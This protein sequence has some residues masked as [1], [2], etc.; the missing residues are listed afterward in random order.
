MR[1]VV[2]FLFIFAGI[3]NG[4]QT[5]KARQVISYDDELSTL[6]DRVTDR[7]LLNQTELLELHHSIGAQNRTQTVGNSKDMMCSRDQKRI[8]LYASHHKSGTE[9]FRNLARYQSLLLGQPPCVNNGCA[10]N[11]GPCTY[12]YPS[13]LTDPAHVYFSCHLFV[14]QLEAIQKFSG[15]DWRAVHVIRDPVALVVS[16]Y[17]YHMRSGNRDLDGQTAAI[18][19]MPMTE[20]LRI[21]AEFALTNAIP[22]MVNAVQW[23]TDHSKNTLVLRL[24]EFTR[25]SQAYDATVRRLYD[26]LAGDVFCPQYMAQLSQMAVKDDLNRAHAAPAGGFHHVAGKDIKQEVKAALQS[27]PADLLTK[28]QD[29]R[30][31]LG[32][33]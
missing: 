10:R 15:G 9:L 27:I 21:E 1:V 17:I 12:K 18:R 14:K 5:Q 28:L 22:Q 13:S 26:F 19:D 4:L 6:I 16:G 30:K 11:G 8:W 23:E 29:A 31:Q 2:F 32:Y 33:A 20:G 7:E 3:V 25:S 24:E